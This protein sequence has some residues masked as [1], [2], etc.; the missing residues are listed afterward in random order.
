V[1]LDWLDDHGHSLDTITGVEVLER[2]VSGRIV[3][4]ELTGR[5]GTSTVVER[6]LNVRRL[7]GGLKSGLFVMDVRR[8][9]SGAIES[10]HF[11]GAG[12]GHGVGMCQTGAMGMAASGKGHRTILKHYYDGIDI[13]TLY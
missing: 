9:Q 13:Q 10:F 2:G 11:N 4:L 3:R 6:E 8:S 12:Y 5:D 1:P 7:F